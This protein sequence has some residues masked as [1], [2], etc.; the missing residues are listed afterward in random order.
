MARVAKPSRPAA[1]F[2]TGIGRAF[3]GALLFAVPLHMTMEMWELG[4]S[5]NRA[6]LV[7]LIV[8]TLPVLFGLSIHT[9][10]ERTDSRIQDVLDALAAFGIGLVS[11][12]IVLALLGVL[13]SGLTFS[14]LVAVVAIAAVPA[15][16]GAVVAN[17]QL[18]GQD[19]EG[20]GKEEDDE[21]ASRDS[22]GKEL[23]L[24]A[25]GAL[26]ISIAV[27]PTEEMVLIAARIDPWHAVAL[28]MTSVAVLHG[29]V[30]A[31]GFAGQEQRP[32]YAGFGLTFFHFSIAGYGIALA[33]AC[34]QL[35]VFE[36]IDGTSL[37]AAAKMA[38]VVGFPASLG[39]GVARLIV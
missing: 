24:M 26:F 1:E 14:G 5:M 4:A 6:R 10:F 31:F 29:L 17:K 22:Y 39:A 21:D 11:S 19:D 37:V 9:G 2:A 18:R 28:V 23:F 13:D 8:I 12:A 32:D 33:V 34:L 20:E 7:V 36:H 27:A 38:A 3:A 16:I 35:W 25:A 15:S 30:Y